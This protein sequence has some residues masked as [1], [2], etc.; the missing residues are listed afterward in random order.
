[1]NRDE[2]HDRR[3]ELPPRIICADPAISGPLDPE[4]NGTW[5]AYNERGY[6][7]CLLNG[8]FEADTNS[9]T[10]QE[11]RGGILCELLSQRDPLDA[12]QKIDPSRYPS[13]RLLVGS[14]HAHKLLTWDGQN[15]AQTPFH[16]T[17]QDRIFFLSSSS[18][19]QDE[20][21]ELRKGL[22]WGW[23]ADNPSAGDEIPSF[24]FSQ[25][26][27]PA[28]APLMTRSYSG[29][30]S[31]TTMDICAERIAMSY[32]KAPDSKLELKNQIA[33]MELQNA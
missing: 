8:Y 27:N 9:S 10:G 4:S 20:V 22:F 30:K 33:R 17:H 28:A 6:W 23:V 32:W 19:K 26:P 1:M 18:W 15:Y 11:S 25:E 2:R 29:T 24:H 7:G 21:I 14:A 12:A 13:F 3:A 31:I 5:M 16:A